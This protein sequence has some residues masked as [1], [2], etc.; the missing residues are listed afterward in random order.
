MKYRAFLFALAFLTACQQAPKQSRSTTN[1][2]MDSTKNGIET[3]TTGKRDTV[4]EIIREEEPMRKKK[5]VFGYRFAIEGD[6]NRDRKRDSLKENLIDRKTG[7][8]APK[9]LDYESM[10]MPT[11]ERYGLKCFL[12]CDSIP[13][14]DIKL[15]ASEIG[16]QYLNNEG[17][18]D[19]DGGDEVSYA[20]FNQEWYL[21][22][23]IYVIT[24]KSKQWK[25]LFQFTG[26][27]DLLPKPEE[28]AEMREMSK[29]KHF[30][31]KEPDGYIHFDEYISGNAGFKKRKIK[32]NPNNK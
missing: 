9:F 8:A 17:D 6:F 27:Y 5:I 25:P 32:L 15:K 31:K 21:G 19:G 28:I 22:R 23:T 20:L 1:G 30:I 10:G 24:C 16:L 29:L 13:P 4:S 7:K 18:L 26:Y 11:P 3:D 14:F 2:A 12:S